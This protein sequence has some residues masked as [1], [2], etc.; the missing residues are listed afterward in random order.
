[1]TLP[2]QIER[3]RCAEVTIS[4]DHRRVSSRLVTRFRDCVLQDRLGRSP[5]KLCTD[6]EISGTVH[7]IQWGLALMDYNG[8]IA[9][10]ERRCHLRLSIQRHFAGSEQLLSWP[11]FSQRARAG[12]RGASGWITWLR[13]ATTSFRSVAFPHVY[14][15]QRFCIFHFV[16]LLRPKRSN[17][18]MKPTASFT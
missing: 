6:D 1:M 13:V 9:G 12:S 14:P 5:V 2:P 4:P 8:S 18:T 15:R 17:Q 3:A 16:A 7:G 10:S 11:L